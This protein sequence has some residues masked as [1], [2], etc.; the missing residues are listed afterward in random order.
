MKKTIC[1]IIFFFLIAPAITNAA[2]TCVLGKSRY[3]PGERATFSCGCSSNNEQNMAGYIV[4][5][6]SSEV[7]QSTLV[8]S[9]PCKN[10]LFGTSYLF[11]TGQ[12]FSGNAT[13][14]LNADGTGI[15]SNWDD[16]TDI[17]TGFFN[18]SGSHITDCLI[19]DIT[20]S[21]FINPGDLGS[22][23]IRVLNGI[24]NNPLVHASCQAEGYDVFGS[25]IVFEP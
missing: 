21:T 15:P 25:P 1:L 13:F 16:G 9:G 2:G 11:T 3:H 22:V 20:G 12:N 19:T 14:S 17:R 8:T 10:S 24:T 6:N 18:V 7:L 5:Q 4:F 23:K